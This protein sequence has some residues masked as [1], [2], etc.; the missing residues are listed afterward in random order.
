[1]IG[2]P[3]EDHTLKSIPLKEYKRLKR[4][5]QFMTALEAAGVDNWEGYSEARRLL[6]EWHPTVFEE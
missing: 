6:K 3:D 1:M 4:V 5:D 2:H